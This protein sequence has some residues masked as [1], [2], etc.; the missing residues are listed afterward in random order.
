MVM[1]GGRGGG[2][3]AFAPEEAQA[4]VEAPNDADATAP[5]AAGSEED[6]DL[7]F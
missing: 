4:A 2:E 6:S 3:A 5:A 7:P 1:L